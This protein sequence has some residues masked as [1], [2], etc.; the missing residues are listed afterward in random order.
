MSLEEPLAELRAAHLVRSHGARD[1][2]AVETYHDRIRETV[3]ASLDGRETE[4]RAAIANAFIETDWADPDQLGVEFLAAVDPGRARQAAIAGAERAAAALAFDRAA[5]LYALAIGMTAHDPARRRGLVRARADVLAY[6]G[7]GEEAALAYLEVAELAEGDERLE[8]ERF[9][10]ENLLRSGHIVRGM[11][12]LSRVLEQ[13]GANVP[14]RR[15]RAVARLLWTRARLGLRG[16]E[17]RRRDESELGARELARVDALFTAASTFAMVDHLRGAAPQTEHLLDALSLGEERRVCRALVTEVGYLAAQGGR[18][19]ERAD[20]VARRV[21][22]IAQR[23]HDPYL[24]AAGHLGM[25]IAAFFSARYRVAV[26][27]CQEADRGIAN[28]VIG[29]WWERTMTRYFLCLAQ[30]NAGDFAGLG[31]T[32]AEAVSEAERRRD[33]FA[34]NLF[35]SHPTVW[36]QMIEDRTAN[37][38]AQVIA[39]LDGWPTDVY[40]QAHHV[41]V[42]ART[43]LRLYDGDAAGAAALLDQSM[44]M[45]RS[46]LIHRLPFVMG[47]VHKLRGQAAVR[48]GDL[49]AATAAARAME[50][51]GVSVG[52]AFAASLRAAISSGRGERDVAARELGVAVERFVETGSAHDAAACRWRLGETVGGSRGDRLVSDANA[53]FQAAGVAAPARMVDFL[54]PRW[55]A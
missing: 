9:A 51:I 54:A 30:I 17:F 35:A 40:Y 14:A 39:S 50:R 45:V 26:D 47:E 4:L 29:A 3:A 53:W 22:T 44:P 25:G 55:R 27:A 10:A 31:R 1:R 28:D 5:A 24:S 46:L 18:G 11:R 32:A 34:R 36:R 2:D 48:C 21:I 13:L 23:I 12:H 8:L 6:A 37:A 42:I 49:G 33:V 19:L 41:A 20:Q 38:E 7:R 52:G 16:L 43:M 15:G